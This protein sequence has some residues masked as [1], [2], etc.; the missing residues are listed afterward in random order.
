M[1]RLTL[2]MI[3]CIVVVAFINGSDIEACK[4]RGNSEA[5]CIEKVSP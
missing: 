5:Y 3:A 2:A 1:I 4:A